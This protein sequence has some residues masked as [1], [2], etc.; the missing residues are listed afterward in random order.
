MVN[1]WRMYLML[2]IFK[3]NWKLNTIIIISVLILITI[4]SSWFWTLPYTRWGDNLYELW[5]NRW[6]FK[7][8]GSWYIVANIILNV[9]TILFAI[10]TI[11][12]AVLIMSK[13]NPKRIKVIIASMIIFTIVLYITS[14][15]CLY[16]LNDFSI[17]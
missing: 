10:S 6:N 15:I 14:I 2:K 1:F 11:V 9:F 5:N 13:D 16:A 12:I 17:Y 4:I 8:F 3:R 7:Y